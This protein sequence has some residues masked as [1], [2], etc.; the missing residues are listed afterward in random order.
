M[1]LSR[2]HPRKLDKRQR[3]TATLT[4]QQE[5]KMNVNF[6]RLIDFVNEAHEATFTYRQR[7]AVYYKA[8]GHGVNLDNVLTD[9]ERRV[10]WAYENDNQSYYVVN[11]LIG[12]LELDY[13]QQ[14]RLHSSARAV[15][16][17]YRD[18][19]Y[20]RCVPRDLIDRLQAYV[21]D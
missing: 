21:M 20:E 1:I 15:R 17:W 5:E 16:R 7:S 18:T 10:Q 12:V 8:H 3:A 2:D 9:D 14:E 13:N 11:G 19:N 6:E 4:R